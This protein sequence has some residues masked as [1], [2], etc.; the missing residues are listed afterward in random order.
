MALEAEEQDPEDGLEDEGHKG[1]E[2]ATVMSESEEEEEDEEDEEP[3]LKYASLTKSLGAVY[4][5]GDATSAFLVAGDKM[6]RY[7]AT[8][9][10]RGVGILWRRTFAECF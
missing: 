5:N 6:V 10:E 7:I 2:N 3:R 9:A 1:A 4:R 8:H